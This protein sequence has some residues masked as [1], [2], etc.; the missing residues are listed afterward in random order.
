M[1]ARDIMVSHVITIGPE[2]ELKAVANTL[3]AN[4]ISAV[5]VVAINGDIVGI[6]SEGDLMRRVAS[7][8][9]RRRSW[10]LELFSSAEQQTAEFTKSYGRKAKDVMTRE[11]ITVEPDAP[12]QQSASLLEQHGIKRVP[13]VKD[14][15]LV[16]IVSRANLVQALASGGVALVETAQ[17]RMKPCGIIETSLRGLPGTRAVV[18]VIVNGG[19]VNLWG[20]VHNEEERNAIRVAAERA[21]GSAQ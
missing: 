2:L 1:K 8:A 20:V 5:P 7:G 3:A 18:N 4:G 10:W 14:G 11:V 21:P 17:R 15:R 13:V 12:L 19:V 9:E 16:G 6:I